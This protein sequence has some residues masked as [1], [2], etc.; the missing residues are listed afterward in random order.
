MKHYYLSCKQIAEA[1]A[2]EI[3]ANNQEILRD[4]TIEELLKVRHVTIKEI[5]D[6][7]QKEN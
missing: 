3:E 6:M 2:K 4:G 7:E 1:A 5:F